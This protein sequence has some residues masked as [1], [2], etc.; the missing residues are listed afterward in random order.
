MGIRGEEGMNKN[1]LVNSGLPLVTEYNDLY[2]NASLEEVLKQ[3]DNNDPVAFYEAAYRYRY[4]E[5]GAEID[6]PKAV[7]L[8]K[9]VLKYQRNTSAMYKLGY[10]YLTGEMGCENESECVVYFEAAAELGHPGSAIQLGI[11][12]EYGDYVEKDYDKALEL[13]NFAIAS[14]R[15]DAYYNAGEIYRHKDMIDEALKCYK[16]ALEN[17]NLS[18]A[19]PLGWFYEDGIGVEKDEKKAFEYYK[20]AYE[21]GNPDSAYY[22]ARMYYLGRGTEESDAKAFPLLKEASEQGNK[23]ANCFLGS[24]YGWGVEGVVEKNI[25]IAMDYLSNVSEAFEVNAWYT[26]GRIYLSENN[27]EE[28]KKWLT[29]AAEGGQEEARQIL[30]QL[31]VPRKSLQELAEEGSDPNAMIKFA[32]MVLSDTEKGGIHKALEI[33]TKAEQLYPN[34]LDVKEMYARIM[35][36]HGHIENKIG[37]YDDSFTTLKQCVATVD[38]LKRNNYKPEVVRDIE[39]DACMECG[40][41]ASRK[42][43]DELTLRMLARTDFQK[44]PYA[45]VLIAL[46]HLENPYKYAQSVHDDIA[47][48]NRAIDTNNWR[49]DTEKAAAYFVLSV[50]YAHGTPNILPANVNYAYE[51]IQKCA[52]IDYPMAENELKKYSKGFLGKIT[53]RG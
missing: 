28:A 1:D 3:A 53:Y 23:N 2:E 17:D 24:M 22:L 39:I 35:F 7:E 30:E 8:Y 25:D 51:C 50:I 40:E 37:A 6:I 9:K 48:I 27:I 15:N 41:M 21:D 31:S 32:G 29:K 4:G 14:G 46:T 33:I 34:N 11:L 36:I 43:E 16:I 19:L 49:N 13:F 5:E 12:Y 47:I 26:K 42:N 10:I 52:E 38:V 20:Q 18:A 45:A 44:Y